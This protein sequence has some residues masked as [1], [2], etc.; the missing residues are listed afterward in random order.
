MNTCVSIGCTRETNTSFC[1]NC[2]NKNTAGKM[3]EYKPGAIE[4]WRKKKWGKV[5]PQWTGPD[6]RADRVGP[7]AGKATG[8]RPPLCRQ[9]SYS[10]AELLKK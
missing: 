6:A 5:V 2:W 4:K 3:E 8:P 9:P 7:R 1:S 10:L